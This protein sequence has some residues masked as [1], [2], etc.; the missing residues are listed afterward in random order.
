MSKSF[1]IREYPSQEQLDKLR[2]VYGQVTLGVMHGV[3]ALL[4][5]RHIDITSTKGLYLVAAAAQNSV[6]AGITPSL[7]SSLVGNTPAAAYKSLGY[8]E[9]HNLIVPLETERMAGASP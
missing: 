9:R 7:T 2:E 6:L 4:R 5:E 3:L 8:F 1:L